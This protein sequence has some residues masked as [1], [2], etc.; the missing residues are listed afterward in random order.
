[1]VL[2]R[3]R[4]DMGGFARFLRGAGDDEWRRALAAGK[5]AATAG[6]LLVFVAGITLDDLHLVR[7]PL[8]YVGIVAAVAVYAFAPPVLA[9]RILARAHADAPDARGP[10]VEGA[11]LRRRAGLATTIVLLLAW[12]VLF[13]SGRTP[14][15]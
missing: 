10:R 13:S 4:P 1:M 3:L 9:S 7:F 2:P 15:W 11:L 5:A 12:L 8:L 14:R 6:S